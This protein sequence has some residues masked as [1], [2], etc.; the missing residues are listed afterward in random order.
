MLNIDD[1]NSPNSQLSSQQTIDDQQITLSSGLQPA[2]SDDRRRRRRQNRRPTAQNPSET[3]DAPLPKPVARG[4][5]KPRG[6]SRLDKLQLYAQI[7]TNSAASAATAHNLSDDFSGGCTPYQR[8]AVKQRANAAAAA[9]AAAKG[10]RTRGAAARKTTATVGGRNRTRA[11]PRGGEVTDDGD[12][13]VSRGPGQHEAEEGVSVPVEK[14]P[15]LSPSSPA[16]VRAT[17]IL[18][19]KGWCMLYVY[20]L[21][22]YLVCYLV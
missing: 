4:P 17:K 21:C 22:Q 16:K 8:A 14:S 9:A 5:A 2:S 19:E 11:P 6:T 1:S 13:V 3:G 7:F 10:S 18:N 20:I 15:R 12:D